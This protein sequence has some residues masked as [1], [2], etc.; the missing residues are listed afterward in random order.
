ML[1]ATPMFDSNAILENWICQGEIAKRKEERRAMPSF[2]KSSFT[3][4]NTAKI[5]KIPKI[6]EGNLT[7]K[8][9][10]PKKLMEGIAKYA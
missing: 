10:N 2:L 4:K 5:D 6:A 7:E 9:F 8:T 1:N 3:K